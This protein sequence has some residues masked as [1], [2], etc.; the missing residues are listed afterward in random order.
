MNLKNRNFWTPLCGSL[1]GAMLCLSPAAPAQD[2]VPEILGETDPIAALSG[3]RFDGT[4]WLSA[5]APPQ[6]SLILTLNRAGT[7][8][9]KDS[10]NGGGYTPSSFTTAEGIWR[11]TGPRSASALGL[12]YVFNADGTTKSVERYRMSFSFGDDL[13]HLTGELQLEEMLCEDMPSPLPFD[14]PICPDPT[15]A[16]TEVLRGP[17]PFSA[18][19]LRLDDPN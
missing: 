1:F 18:V 11:R 12:R 6:R 8:T 14:V 2:P 16:P 4:W 5:S 15:V 10:I 9:I 3:N 17:A 7:F 13:D 19:R